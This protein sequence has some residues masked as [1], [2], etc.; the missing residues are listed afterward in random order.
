MS[1]VQL[2]LAIVLPLLL[3]LG[4]PI[5]AALGLTGFAAAYL[6]DAQLVFAPQ[7]I[8]NGVDNFAL[9]AIPAF[10]LAGNIMEKG[11][12]THDI[13]RIFRRAFGNIPGSLGIVTIFSCMFFAAISGSG[14]GTVAAIGSI[15]IPSMIRYGYPAPY[16]ASVTATGG[17]LGVLI[18]P[19]NPMII[20][21]VI[22]NV[23]IADMFAAGLIPGLIL[24]FVLAFTAY[25]VAKKSGAVV[26]NL[27]DME[28]ES[29]PALV[30]KGKFALFL[31]VLILG[32]IYSGMFTPVEA[33]VVAVVY[34]LLVA[35]FIYRKLNREALSLA[36]EQTHRIGGALMIVVAC[37]TL[38]AT[39]ITLENIPQQISEAFSG[40]STNP[41]VIL[42]WINIFLLFVGTF[43]ETISAIIILAPILVPL[44]T[45]FGINP[46]HF[47]IILVTNIQI[48]FLTPPLGVNLFVASQISGLPVEKI[49]RSIWP[50]LL[51]LLGVLTLVT[52]VPQLSLFLPSLLRS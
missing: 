6:L 26:N 24:G 38:L 48:A 45:A 30:W 25:I 23:S 17:T 16:A 19:S 11:G 41:L 1:N 52:L 3:L 34:S 49:I 40:I 47:G 10:I 21:A 8:F 7:A 33:S 46:V 51:A 13:I 20:Y 35:R 14:P 43:M 29:V 37:S 4:V 28:T 12:L 39:T 5:Y 42:L 15:M 50:F 32:G 31:P 2:V 36:F 27:V 44:V 18:P 22:A 9:L